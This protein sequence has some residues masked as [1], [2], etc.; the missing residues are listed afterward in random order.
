MDVN[1]N[2]RIHLKR[3]EKGK[4]GIMRR[5]E[6]N[7]KKRRQGPKYTRMGH[8]AQAQAQVSSSPSNTL[9]AASNRLLKIFADLRSGSGEVVIA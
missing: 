1:C 4:L 8:R 3:K 2:E 6:G 7:K 9:L 5:K